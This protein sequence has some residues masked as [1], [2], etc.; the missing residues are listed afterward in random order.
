MSD[1][2]NLEVDVFCIEAIKSLGEEGLFWPT[3]RSAPEHHSMFVDA[4]LLRDITCDI[5]F[6]RLLDEL[7]QF[8]DLKTQE[9]ASFDVIC[10][11]WKA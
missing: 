1:I 10:L 4:A 3:V 2:L 7:V 6:D 11:T 5:P 8:T 9:L